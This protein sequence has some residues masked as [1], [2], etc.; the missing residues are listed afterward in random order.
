MDACVLR[1]HIYQLTEWM[2][3]EEITTFFSEIIG[4]FLKQENFYWL[5]AIRRDTLELHIMFI[6]PQTM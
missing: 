6:M 4:L 5:R 1:N 3:V 2:N